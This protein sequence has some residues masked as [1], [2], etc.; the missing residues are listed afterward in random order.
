VATWAT[1]IGLALNLAGVVLLFRY[2]MPYR[3]RA[4]GGSGRV[5]MPDPDNVKAERR[6]TVL[7]NVGLMLIVAGT[8][9][10]IF[11]ALV[12]PSPPAPTK[13][14]VQPAAMDWVTR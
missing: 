7:C 12:P 8:A 5:T 9:S 4:G 1:V 14:F 13:P 3:V 6:Y 11:A 2:G 10:Q